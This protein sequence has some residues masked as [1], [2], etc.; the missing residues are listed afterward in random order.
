MSSSSEV[1]I[2]PEFQ[3]A[4]T[5]E[6]V[7]IRCYSEIVPRWDKDDRIGIGYTNMLELYHVKDDD[8]GLYYCYGIDSQGKRFTAVSR[9]IVASKFRLLIGTFEFVSYHLIQITELVTMKPRQ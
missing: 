8:T 4:F 7:C 2:R 6:I 9:L 1:N 3:T 5:G